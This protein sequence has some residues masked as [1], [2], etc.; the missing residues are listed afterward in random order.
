MT[1][2]V[3]QCN[4]NLHKRNVVVHR[5]VVFLRS[6]T[7]TGY[8]SSLANKSDAYFKFVQVEGEV[9]NK[10]VP[11]EREGDV[12]P[13]YISIPEGGRKRRKPSSSSPKSVESY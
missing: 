10:T 13:P 7:A 12:D 11:L 1:F 6:Q 5:G 9:T 3:L 4:E 8:N 2:K